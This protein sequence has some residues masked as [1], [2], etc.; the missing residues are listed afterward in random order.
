M[1]ICVHCIHSFISGFTHLFII[2]VCKVKIWWRFLDW[3]R[4]FH[5]F[6]P[7]PEHILKRGFVLFTLLRSVSSCGRNSFSFLFYLLGR[8]FR[9]LFG[10]L[11]LF[12][13]EVI[14]KSSSSPSTSRT[15]RRWFRLLS[16]LF[17]NFS[18]LL[19][20]NF[21]HGTS[22]LSYFFRLLLLYFLL[23]SFLISFINFLLPNNNPF[24]IIS[25]SEP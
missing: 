11:S 6:G 18:F 17:I 19:F 5:F 3:W 4:L 14:E 7:Y 15:R 20:L 21:L 10:G 13:K 12:S 8:L 25:F 16:F 9:S 24:L 1:L 2:C 22:F 23:F